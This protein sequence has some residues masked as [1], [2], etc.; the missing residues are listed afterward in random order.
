M[1]WMNYI[2]NRMFTIMVSLVMERRVSDTLCGTKAMFRWDY[3]HM[4]MGRDP[5]GDYDFLF[6][7]AQLRLLVRELPVH[8]RDRTAGQSKM[9]AM[10]H[11]LNLLRMC[12]QGFWQVKT[13]RRVPAARFDARPTEMLSSVNPEGRASV[14]ALTVNPEGRASVPALVSPAGEREGGHGGPPLRTS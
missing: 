14:P 9:K 2:G 12:W 4:T 8:Y 3:A 1:K 6:G 5:W 7:A 10:K 11:T 13:L